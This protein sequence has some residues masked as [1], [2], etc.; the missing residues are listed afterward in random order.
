MNLKNIV[1][2]TVS[3]E[4]GLEDFIKLRISVDSL[5]CDPSIDCWL[6]D[7]IRSTNHYMRREIQCCGHKV[8]RWTP[9]QFYYEKSW[10]CFIMI[11]S[12]LGIKAKMRKINF[13][14]RIWTFVHRMP[15]TQSL[16][17]YIGSTVIRPVWFWPIKRSFERFYDKLATNLCLYL[18]FS[19]KRSQF[20]EFSQKHLRVQINYNVRA[21]H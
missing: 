3:P 4:L 1:W 2:P 12:F 20:S 18:I 8:V 14:M 13:S 10:T 16:C 19:G 9:I 11:L 6:V 5:P 21:R 7:F 17:I 15:R